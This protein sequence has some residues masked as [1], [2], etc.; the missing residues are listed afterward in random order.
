M[1]RK[2]VSRH[3]LRHLM[4]SFRIRS[5]NEMRCNKTQLDQLN[6]VRIM[7]RNDA[8]DGVMRDTK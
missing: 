4:S 6:S 3:A 7:H 1:T 8:Q 5:M 2:I